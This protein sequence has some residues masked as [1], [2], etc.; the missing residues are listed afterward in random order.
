MLE[1]WLN[2]CKAV[3][4]N[5]QDTEN[6]KSLKKKKSPKKSQAWN[7]ILEQLFKIPTDRKRFLGLYGI[8]QPSKLDT[9]QY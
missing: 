2:I 1:D 4:C 3:S 6:N 5:D 7:Y 8:V 9:R